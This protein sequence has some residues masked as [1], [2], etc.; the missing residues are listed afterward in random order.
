MPKDGREALEVLRLELQFLEQGGYGRSVSTPWKWSSTF[1]HSPSCINYNL[2]NKPHRCSECRLIDFV[3]VE[4][5]GEDVPCHSIPIGPHGETVREMEQEHDLAELED[6][7]RNWLRSQ[8][9]VLERQLA[10]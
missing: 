10:A 1:E 8:I 4:V 6:A 5:R 3:P 2:I 9:E 7:L